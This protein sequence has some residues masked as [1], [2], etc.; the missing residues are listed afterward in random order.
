M[1]VFTPRPSIKM[2]R[3]LSMGTMWIMVLLHEIW[4]QSMT[5][6]PRFSLFQKDFLQRN[7]TK[8]IPDQKYCKKTYHSNYLEI[9]IEEY[10]YAKIMGGINFCNIS[11]SMMKVVCLLRNQETKMNSLFQAVSSSSLTISQDTQ[12]LECVII[13]I[14]LF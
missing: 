11:Y 8:I 2:I 10:S 13:C 6:K 7:N 14:S 12:K 3:N 4:W 9:H 1:K 5:L